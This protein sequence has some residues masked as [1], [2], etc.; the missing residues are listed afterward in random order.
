M[1]KYIQVKGKR[2]GVRLQSWKE[3]HD[4]GGLQEIKFLTAQECRKPNRTLTA[5]TFNMKVSIEDWWTY[6]K[7]EIE[8]EFEKWGW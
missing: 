3:Y 5:Y 8:V 4:E 2:R 6:I 7:P 1:L